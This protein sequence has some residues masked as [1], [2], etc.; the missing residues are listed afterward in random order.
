MLCSFKMQ[1]IQIQRKSNFPLPIKVSASFFAF[2]LLTFFYAHSAYA[3]I[4]EVGPKKIYK[5]ISNVPFDSLEPGD[6]VKIYYKAEPY[7]EKFIIRCSGTKDNPIIIK[8]IPHKGKRPVID[9]SSASQG[10]KERW[11]QSGRWLIKAG[12]GTPAHYVQIKNLELRNANNLQQYRKKGSDAEYDYEDNAAGVFIRLGR[13]VLISNCVIHS[14]GNGIQT[15]YG[16][17]VSH[18][19]I[20]GCLIYD[21]GNHKN[22]NSSQEHN[23]YLCGTHTTVQFC[24][25]GVPHSD[26]NNIKDRGVDTIIRYNWIE[27]GKNRQ[28]DLVDHKEYVQADAY[29]Y[30][31]VIV[32]GQDVNNDN[33][34]HWGGDSGSSRSGTL[35]LFNNTI[36]GKVKTTRFI[37]VR[38]PDCNVEIKNNVFVGSGKLWNGKGILF[39]SNNWFSYDITLHS[40]LNVGIQGTM[41]GFLLV[42]N[43]QYMPGL[44]SILINMGTNKVPKRMKYMPRSFT[45]GIRRPQDKYMDIGAFEAVYVGKQRK[46]RVKP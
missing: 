20:S 31:N 12:D 35:Y 39:G 9:G 6:T 21:N 30:G 38:Y 25:F 22:L 36:V 44:G 23:V 43:M 13:N 4:Y 5:T 26:G 41:P 27:G 18:A 24:R 45:G 40:S 37:V 15:T 1:K 7:H 10:Q 17:D 28:I 19:K 8:G 34:I 2:L 16:P 3:A 46:Q 14:C 42:P 11:T 33:M 32:Q 29:V